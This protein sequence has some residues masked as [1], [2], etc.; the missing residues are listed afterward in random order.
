MLQDFSYCSHIDAV[1]IC[2]VY[3]F[4]LSLP[5]AVRFSGTR[6]D[7]FQVDSSYLKVV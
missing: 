3:S 4:I 7:T 2:V 1:G 5:L 6:N